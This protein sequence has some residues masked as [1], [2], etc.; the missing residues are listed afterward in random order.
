MRVFLDTNVFLYAAGQA[1]P[2]REACVKVLRRVAEGTLEATANSEVIQEILYVL[3]HRGRGETGV[4][5][6]RHVAALFPDLL[7][8]TGEDMRRA[9]DLVER[10]PTLSVRD[11]VH[12]ATMLGNG[13]Q[14]VISVD[15]DF[16]QIREIRRVAP[17]NI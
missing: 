9:C 16:D 11:A 8:V 3:V 14:Q 7:P 13:L 2:R 6:A 15:E 4:T 12:A 1:H 5:L 17:E 10:Y